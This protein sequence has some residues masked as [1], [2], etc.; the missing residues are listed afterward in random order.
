MKW[1]IKLISIA[2]IAAVVA[3]CFFIYNQP[4]YEQD[5]FTY[6]FTSEQTKL[7]PLN[8]DFDHIEILDWDYNKVEKEPKQ[9]IYRTTYCPCNKDSST[10]EIIYLDRPYEYEIL[11]K[12]TDDTLRIFVPKTFYKTE[13]NTT[14]EYTTNYLKIKVFMEK[15]LVTN[16]ISAKP[17]PLNPQSPDYEY[18]IITNETLWSTFNDNFKDWKI[19]SDS[20]INDI[21]IVNVSDILGWRSYSVNSTCGDATNESM[22]NHWIPDGKEVTTAYGLFNDTQAQIRNFLRDCYDTENTRYVLLGGNKNMVPPR[23]ATT[24]A[25]GDGCNSYDN[26]MSHAS[27]M[28]YACLHYCMNNNTNSYWMESECCGNVYDEVDWGFDLIVGRVPVDTPVELNLWINKTKAY[29]SGNDQGNY[30]SRQICAA[31]DGSNAITNST[32]VDLGGE[33]AASIRRQVEPITNFTFVNNQNITQAQWS[34]MDDYVNGDIAG[35]D[36]INMILQAGHADYHSGRLWDN[37]QPSVCSNSETPNFVYTE[38]CKCGAFGTTTVTCVEDWMSDDGC[39]Y[40][41][42]VN[43]A[44]GWFGAST[45]FV[46]NLLY[47]MFNESGSQIR[48]FCE[49]HNHARETQG[50]TTADGVWAMI[51][52]ETNFFGDPALDWVWYD[53]LEIIDIDNNVNRSN[54]HNL[55]PIFNWTKKEGTARYWLQISNTSDF[56]SVYINITDINETI[57]PDEYSENVTAVSFILPDEYRLCCYRQYYIRIRNIYS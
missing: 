15:R 50:H 54:I 6:S 16:A 29:V 2:I 39:M 34:V 38:G 19:A 45:F 40:A 35:W 48:T 22:G 44:Y 17:I 33:Y 56:S 9:P 30:L 57:Y 46:E 10:K 53:P 32:W 36:G 23:M 14:Y 47:D 28:Y 41:G 18:V 37:Y 49:A 43:S 26:D 25:S 12:G 51:Y 11:K 4:Y 55:N 42:I 21:W 13:S 3:I 7:I 20:K 8:Q 52:K 5:S 27:D 24:R 1:T 31:K